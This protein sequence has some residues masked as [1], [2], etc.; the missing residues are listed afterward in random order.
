[1][2]RYSRTPKDPSLSSGILASDDSIVQLCG[3]WDEIEGRAG[4]AHCD[5]GDGHGIQRIEA[6]GCSL[7]VVKLKGSYGL[8]YDLGLCVRLA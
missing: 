4:A 8:S 2:C 6:T 1:V 3:N 5:A 7:C